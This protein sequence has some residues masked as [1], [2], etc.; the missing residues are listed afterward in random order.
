[1]LQGMEDDVRGSV[2]PATRRAWALVEQL[3]P[4]TMVSHCQPWM[5][6]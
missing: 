6:V 2:F 4:L 1:M 5:C 3:G